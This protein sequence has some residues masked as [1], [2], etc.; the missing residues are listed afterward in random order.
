MKNVWMALLALIAGVLVLIGL[1]GPAP[2]KPEPPP[3]AAAAPL[4]P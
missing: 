4:S 2:K 1:S 3:V